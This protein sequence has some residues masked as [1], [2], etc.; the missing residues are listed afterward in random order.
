MANDT[1][2]GHLIKE[3]FS[4]PNVEMLNLNLDKNKYSKSEIAL[5]KNLLDAFP[6]VFAVLEISIKR[7]WSPYIDIYMK[8][9]MTQSPESYVGV[10]LT[11]CCKENEGAV[12]IYDR[13]LNVFALV[14]Y[15]TNMIFTAT[16]ENLYELSSQILTV[17]YENV[18]RQD[19]DK[20]GGWK[21]LKKYIQD[22]N[23]VKCFHDC[24]KHKFVTDDFP[25]KLKLKIRDSFSSQ[26]P[27]V[28]RTY[29]MEAEFDRMVDDLKSKAMS[30]AKGS[31]L[32]DLNSPKLNN[33]LS[34]SK[35]TEISNS[36]K[37]NI[38]EDSGTTV[39]EELGLYALCQSKIDELENR[40]QYLVGIFE[41]LDEM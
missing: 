3:V 17:F 22:K 1:I 25:K 41:L 20:C 39:S 36:S 23:Y 40:L 19:F 34:V 14:N 18:L 33:N 12:D 31:P 30:S 35:E 11:I 7:N 15:V 13:F 29:E 24:K 26:P 21:C 37:A 5:I 38:L 8:E 16:G 2:F 27:S 28:P 32:N 6:K 4:N 9:L 10:M